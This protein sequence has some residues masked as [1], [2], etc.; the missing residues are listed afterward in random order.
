M[1]QHAQAPQAARSAQAAPARGENPNRPPLITRAI[2]LRRHR[3]Q[4]R[5]RLH[6]AG[7]NPLAVLGSDA[8]QGAMGPGDANPAVAD[9]PGE[10][11]TSSM[12]RYGAPTTA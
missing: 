4:H 6:G 8:A 12:A 11:P 2:A 7:T 5:H 1:P 9:A 3:L 10:C